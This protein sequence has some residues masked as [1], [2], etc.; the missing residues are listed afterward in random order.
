MATTL[1]RPSAAPVLEPRPTERPAAAPRPAPVQPP[2]AV[3]KRPSLLGAAVIHLL[4]LGGTLLL[5]FGA[6]SLA[7][8]MRMEGLR[9]TQIQARERA[10]EARMVVSTLRQKIE[11]L[12]SVRAVDEWAKVRN[13]T[14]AFAPVEAQRD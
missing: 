11:R 1:E 3:R 2:R 14:L 7:G 5:S 6:S 9:R 12:A 10:I 13:F 4:G 8:Q